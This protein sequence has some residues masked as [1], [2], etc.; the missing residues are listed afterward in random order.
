MRTLR[1]VGCLVVLECIVLSML[2]MAVLWGTDVAVRTYFLLFAG[3]V[4]GLLPIAVSVVAT[5]NPRAA[6]GMILCA[7][8]PAVF[9]ALLFSPHFGGI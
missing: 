5:Y 3:V 2:I 1:I 9:F 8:P 6:A 4:A 7:V